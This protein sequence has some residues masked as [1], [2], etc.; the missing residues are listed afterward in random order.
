MTERNRYESFG[1]QDRVAIVTG[2]SQG[3]GKALAEGLAEAGAH[4]ALVS[5]TRE[6]LEKAAR[7]LETWG[8]QALVVPT[9]LRNVAEI[10]EMVRQVH[11]HFGR[12]DILINNAAWTDTRPA[13]EVTEDEWD[14]TMDT[15]LKSVFFASQAVASHMIEQGKGSIVNVGS[16][17]GVV[18]FAGRPVYGAAKAGVHQLTRC[19]AYEWA[20]K[21]IR[22][23][24]MAPS[25][26]ETP[27][28]QNL[29]SNPEYREWV[30]REMFPIR[31]WAQPEDLVGATLFLCS[32]MAAMMV[33]HV[34][35]VDGGWTI[36]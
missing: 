28:R 22:V 4:V 11:N 8:Q 9:D 26:T 14:R 3:I 12:I 2:A 18:A 30:T 20:E 19:L 5:R 10:W 23:N 1:L 27:T 34:M 32:D 21:G 15:S 31:R 13:L 17:L 29:F 24:S 6:T 36:H 7:E 33:G 16:T 25:V 35:L